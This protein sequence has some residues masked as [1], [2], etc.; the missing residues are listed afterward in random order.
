MPA[1]RWTSL[2][3]AAIALLA[4]RPAAATV[5]RFDTVLGNIDVRLYDQAKPLSAA[6][7]L[8]YV[9]RGDYSNTLIHRS[10]PNFIIQGGGYRF[11][12]TAQVEPRNYPLVPEQPPVLN[13][14]GI[15]NIRGTL[16]YAKIGPP[17]N[18]PPTPE[19]INSATSEWFFNLADNRGTPPDGLDFQNGGFT[20]FGRVIG[21]GMTIA[22]QIAAVPRFGFLPPWDEA[23]MR[24]YTAQE[25]FALTPVD[26]DNVVNLSIFTLNIP[27]GDYTFDGVTN[28]AD[29]RR[30]VRDLG[31]S[32][33]AEA[34]GNGNAVV[35]GGD[36]LVWQRSFGQNFGAPPPVAAVP[37]PAALR[38]AALAALGAI[39]ARRRR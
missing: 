35:E 13:E 9:T 26:A 16:A 1:R 19:T 37:E 36:F 30:W 6:N 12:N 28:A 18:Q 17:E 14:P 38:L 29:F 4:S 22:D 27:A 32:T 3:A 15:S 10:V 39:T 23:P 5:V 25:Y 11:N 2:A 7:F 34:D 31:S 24:N 21:A 8:G 33:L 20:A